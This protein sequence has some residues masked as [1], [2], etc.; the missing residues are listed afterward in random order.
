MLCGVSDQ[1]PKRKRP[2]SA[3]L[4]IAKDWFQSSTRTGRI[5][6][7]GSARTGSIRI[8]RSRLG[9]VLTD[10]PR[11]FLAELCRA[12]LSRQQPSQLS[13]LCE[14]RLNV[15]HQSIGSVCSNQNSHMIWLII[16]RVSLFGDSPPEHNEPAAA[17]NELK[18][19]VRSGTNGQQPIV[20]H[21][22]FKPVGLVL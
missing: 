8:P 11:S 2:R 18:V 12:Q 15:E 16:E 20:L 3:D 14:R 21:S 5:H 4:S 9:C 1:P 10:W 13:V 6:I 19:L 17:W 22:K 7:Q